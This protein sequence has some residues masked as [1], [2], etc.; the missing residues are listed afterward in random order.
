MFKIA[1]IWTQKKSWVQVR[2]I[3]MLSRF[4]LIQTQGLIYKKKRFFSL[5]KKKET[6][7]NS[8]LKI[9]LSIKTIICNVVPFCRM[10]HIISNAYII[11]IWY[12]CLISKSI[13]YVCKQN[14]ILLI[15]RKYVINITLYYTFLLWTWFYIDWCD[16]LEWLLFQLFLFD[17]DRC[18]Y[19]IAK[20]KLQLTYKI[21]IYKVSKNF[22]IPKNL[23]KKKF[24]PLEKKKNNA[25]IN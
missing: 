3:K 11:Q 1:Y 16:F 14:H 18:K 22:L 24:F 25:I 8:V 9:M 6:S 13:I 2:C 7:G 12:I 19:Y 5:S 23:Y 15:T 17:I 20:N 10:H 4:G 21:Y